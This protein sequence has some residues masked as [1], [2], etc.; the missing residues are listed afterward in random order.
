MERIATGYSVLILLEI[1][2]ERML[3][4]LPDF[5]VLNSTSY[6]MFLVDAGVQGDGHEWSDE[7]YDAEEESMDD[8]GRPITT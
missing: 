2:D 1:I 6:Q 3:L 5:F 7:H 8:N 4:F